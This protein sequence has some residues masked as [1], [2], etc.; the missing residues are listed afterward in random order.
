MPNIEVNLLFIIAFNKR[1]FLIYFD[2][3][4][5]RIIDKKNERCRRTWLYKKRFLRIN[6]LQ[7]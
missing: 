4:M 6:E 2:N 7:L 3:Q 5:I 1:E